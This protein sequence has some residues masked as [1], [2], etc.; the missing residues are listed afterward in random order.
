MRGE[1]EIFLAMRCTICP[2]KIGDSH[3]QYG[4]PSTLPFASLEIGR[5]LR[6]TFAAETP[7]VF[8]SQ[9]SNFMSQ[10][11]SSARIS[12]VDQHWQASDAVICGD[13][14]IGVD[15]SLWFQTVVRG[16][17]APISIGSRT[18]V[19]EHCV[20]H[21][22]GGEP[23]EIGEEVTIGHGAVVHGL[24]V[25]RGTLIGMK[26]VILGRCVVGEEC[27]IGAGAVLSPGTVVPDRSVVMGVPAKVVRSVR[28]EELASIRKNMEHY[29]ELA[30]E[31]SDMPEKFYR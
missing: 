21:C 26:A 19:Q 31:H 4:R 7:T 5:V 23:L 24:K 16:D 22:D 9:W 12:R 30:R 8:L 20:L 15:C 3:W 10:F 2:Q 27:I 18:N 13:V 6:H 1:G 29:V 28:E 17:V 25:G 14:S 11:R